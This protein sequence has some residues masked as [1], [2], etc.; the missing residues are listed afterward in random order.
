MKWP[1][2]LLA[3]WKQREGEFSSASGLMASESLIQACLLSSYNSF[4]PHVNAV[5]QVRFSISILWAWNVGMERS[6]GLSLTNSKSGKHIS[7]LCVFQES[8]IFC[9]SSCINV[10]VQEHPLA[11][12]PSPH[13]L[14]SP[15]PALVRC[16]SLRDNRAFPSLGLVGVKCLVPWLLGQ[17]RS[18]E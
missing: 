17:R 8:I 3:M 7:F 13:P 6:R 4:S 18:T 14:P 1:P 5:R 16:S 15:A 9:C 12:V 2:Y 10:V 11:T